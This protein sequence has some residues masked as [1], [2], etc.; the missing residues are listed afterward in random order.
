MDHKLVHIIFQYNHYF[1]N[2][3]KKQVNFVILSET[4]VMTRRTECPQG[5]KT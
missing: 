1:D 2:L 5:V 4:G 3:H